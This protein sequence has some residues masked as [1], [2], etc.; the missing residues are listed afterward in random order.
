MHGKITGACIL[1]ALVLP[2]R[3]TPPRFTVTPL[4]TL[5]GLESQANAINSLG[6]IVGW[7]NDT[8]GNQ[9][10]FFY[11][12]GVIV[13]LGTLGGSA[14]EALALNDLDQVVG[15]STTSNGVKHA[16]VFRDNHMVD[17]G[18][19]GG[20][21]SCATGINNAGRIVG[22]AFTCGYSFSP[23]CEGGYPSAGQW[24]RER[25]LFLTPEELAPP[26]IL[27][28]FTRELAK[29]AT[30][31]WAAPRDG[32][33]WVL[34]DPAVCDV[35]LSLLMPPQQPPDPLRLHYLEGLTLKLL[36]A[37]LSSLS[38]SEKRDLLL[39]PDSIRALRPNVVPLFLA[40][41]SQ[42]GFV[43]RGSAAAP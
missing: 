2:A 29:A 11:T 14:S 15:W 1:L 3:A 22:W 20:T 30:R 42:S 33:A 19:L 37:G 10:A 21:D 7:S 17:L 39:N 5:G 12:S 28:Q 34:E 40:P 41:P 4:G 13:N 32:L 6:H 25:G 36:H 9:R 8:N 38:S 18:T 24:M 35:H 16:F 26:E 23:L 43:P 31:P 27:N